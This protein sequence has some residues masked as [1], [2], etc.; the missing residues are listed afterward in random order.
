[1]FVDLDKEEAKIPLDPEMLE[2]SAIFAR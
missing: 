1:M 2:K